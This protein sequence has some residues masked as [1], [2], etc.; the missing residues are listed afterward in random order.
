MDA[1]F[2]SDGRREPATTARTVHVPGCNHAFVTAALHD[3]RLTATPIP[4]SDDIMFQ[5]AARFLPRM[6]AVRHRAT[7][8]AFT[9]LFS[10]RRIQQ[11]RTHI[12]ATAAQLIDAFPATGPMD[13]VTAFARPL[14]LAVICEVLGVPHDQQPWLAERM[15]TFG[16]GFAGQRERANV[17][18]GNAAAVAMLE[19][20]DD[21]LRQRQRQPAQ[22]VLSLLALSGA[23]EERRDDLLANCLFFVLAGHATTTALI[24]AGVHLLA[25]HPDQLSHVLSDQTTWSSAVEELLRFVSPTTLTG[26]TATG[27]LQVGGCPVP[28]G[29][30]RAMVFAAANRDPSVFENPDSF[31]AARTPNPHLAFSAG[32]H[33]CLGAPLARLHGE[34]ALGLL[35]HR[36]PRLHALGE[37]EWLGSVPIRQVAHLSVDWERN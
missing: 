15:E 34:V 36:L 8:G 7:R 14:P 23:A 29:A 25:V 22:D 12:E 33:Y 1:L 27:D 24:T 6:D 17:E 18:A 37:P 13:I 20:F 28:A 35:F 16:R 32:V 26:V 2:T 5:V 21:L 19:L 31:D 30:S 4:P 11:Y 3:R 10:P 9:G